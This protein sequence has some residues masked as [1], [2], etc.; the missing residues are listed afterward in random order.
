MVSSTWAGA[1][2]IDPPGPPRH[3]YPASYAVLWHGR[4]VGR[5]HRQQHSRGVL[6]EHPAG[7]RRGLNLAL[8]RDWSGSPPAS[9][10]R[11]SGRSRP[12]TPSRCAARAIQDL[13]RG[14][15]VAH[16]VDL[17]AWERVLAQLPVDQR[18]A[19]LR[20]VSGVGTSPPLAP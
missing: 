17:L 2:D 19:Y 10:G 6:R 18:L 3:P 4:G 7:R 14:Q 11:F 16:D 12:P 13:T 8:L 20:E 15:Q 1:V 5:E 9:S